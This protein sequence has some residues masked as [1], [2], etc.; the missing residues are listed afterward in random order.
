[1]DISTILG[2]LLNT[3]TIDAASEQTNLDKGLIQKILVA[4]APYLLKGVLAQTSESEKK[5]GVEKALS[6]HGKKDASDI[7]QFL[8]NVDVADGAKILKHLLGSDSKAATTDIA[9]KSGTSSKNVNSLLSLL[10]PLLMTLIG[11]QIS[12]QSTEK[13][14]DDIGSLLGGLL[15]GVLSGGNSGKDDE[16]DSSGGG[17]MLGALL[18]G[19]LK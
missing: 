16:E 18:S 14:D 6:D 11:Q 10:A 9:K 13:K 4:A 12:Q 19:L 8:D 2:A 3:Q 15:G 17:S 5:K 1:M 7:T